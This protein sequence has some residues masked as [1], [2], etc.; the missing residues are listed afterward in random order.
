MLKRSKV[1]LLCSSCLHCPHSFFQHFQ[2]DTS[3]RLGTADHPWLQNDVTGVAFSSQCLQELANEAWELRPTTSAAEATSSGQHPWALA[4]NQ[5]SMGW[6]S[7]RSIDFFHTVSRGYANC[8][9]DTNHCSANLWGLE[10]PDQQ[11]C[12]A[13]IAMTV[14]QILRLISKIWIYLQSTG[15]RCTVGSLLLF[16]HIDS[17]MWSC[18]QFKRDMLHFCCVYGTFLD[19]RRDSSDGQTIF[20]IAWKDRRGKLSVPTDKPW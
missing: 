8:N 19:R 13:M 6:K 15:F 5:G 7:L 14:S 3:V 12:A 17:M 10:R 9:T 4:M 1:M 16:N 20:C 18:H 11:A 2:P